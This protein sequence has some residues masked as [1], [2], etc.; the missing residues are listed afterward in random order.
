MSEEPVVTNGPLSW[1]DVYAAVERSEERLMGR[2]DKFETAVTESF[3]EHDRRLQKIDDRH[4][5]VDA[6]HL[7]QGRI[8]RWSRGA[9]IGLIALVNSIIAIA[10][11]IDALGV[12]A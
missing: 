3:R 6:Q 5:R 4:L 11:A 8:F 7:E 1:R 10:V 9:V 2:F 12:R